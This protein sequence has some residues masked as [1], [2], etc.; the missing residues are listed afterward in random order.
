MEGIVL[1]LKS[2]VRRSWRR[3]GFAALAVSCLAIGVG[4]DTALFSVLRAVVL[5]PLPF[6]EPERLVLLWSVY[7]GADGEPGEYYTSTDNLLALRRAGTLSALVG[8][9]DDD[10]DVSGQGGKAERLRGVRATW[11]VFHA[12]GARALVGRLFDEADARPG[13]ARVA[14]IAEG[15]WRRRFGA[16]DDVLGRRLLVDRVAHTIVGVAAGGSAFPR[17]AELWVPLIPEELSAERRQRGMLTVFGRLAPGAALGA[18]QAEL[19]GIAAAIREREPQLYRGFGV[20]IGP[21]QEELTVALRPRLLAL[22]AGVLLLLGIACANVANLLLVRVEQ[23]RR[24]VALHA[25]L[26]ASRARQIRRALIDASLLAVAGAALGALA[27]SAGLPLLLALVPGETP[28]LDRA[29]IDVSVLGF[30]FVLSLSAV[31]LFGIVPAVVG[32][33]TDPKDALRATESATASRRGSRISSSF[34]ALQV[35]VSVVLL[36]GTGIAAGTLSRLQQVDPGFVARDVVSFRLAAP[37]ARYPDHAARVRFYER[38]IAA[39]RQLPGVDA[40]GGAHVLPIGDVAF[41][42]HYSVEGHPP[43]SPDERNISFLRVITPGFLEALGV[44]LLEGR[45]F[46]ERDG[47]DAPPVAIVSAALARRYWPGESALGKR[48]K[49]QAYDAPNPWMSVVGVAGD[50][51]DGGLADEVA[52]AVYLPLPQWDYSYTSLMSF[53]V[54][55]ARPPGE[56]LPALEARVHRL[57]PDA[58]V[59]RSRS[60]ADVLRESLASERFTAVLMQVFAGIGLALA[61][62]GVYGVMSTAAE[63]RRRELAIRAACGATGKALALLVLHRAAVVTGLGLALGMAAVGG[64]ASLSPELLPDPAALP[65]VSAATLGIMSTAALLAALIPALRAARVDAARSLR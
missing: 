34:V 53:A 25:A 42:L 8:V 63:Q 27:A 52:P 55:S 31:S 2:A 39:A 37:Q 1:D 29:G 57:D 20:R 50:I 7:P 47:P 44:R 40:A 51:R 14:V 3:P 22:G 56:L 49:H 36:F 28:G 15:T 45:D 32:S 62:V 60:L 59:F 33:R 13:A 24:V 54:R 5:A 12:T 41:G 64:I 21:L 6:A 16:R 48:I 26:G 23:E 58:A 11:D 35:A 46:E 10:L 4:A 65:G 38:V 18:A 61:G 30:A 17:H 9:L 43:K 19:E